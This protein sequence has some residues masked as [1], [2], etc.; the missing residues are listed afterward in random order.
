VDGSPR[1]A[2][3]FGGA[4]DRTEGRANRP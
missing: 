4:K 2:G 3:R 1:R